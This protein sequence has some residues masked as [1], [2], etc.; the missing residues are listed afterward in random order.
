ML[1]CGGIA[2]KTMRRRWILD[3]LEGGVDKICGEVRHG[4]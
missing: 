3:M 4:M 1:V 2:M